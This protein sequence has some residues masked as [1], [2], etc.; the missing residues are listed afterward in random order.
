M[1][2][3]A[4]YQVIYYYVV[5]IY[6]YHMDGLCTNADQQPV[7][8]WTYIAS[9]KYVFALLLPQRAY[10]NYVAGRRQFA[11]D[12]LAKFW[13]CSLRSINSFR[14]HINVLL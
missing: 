4:L 11:I 14:N 12:N 1:R 3:K 8:N 13:I 7:H 9:P 5:I 10:S 2:D 6:R